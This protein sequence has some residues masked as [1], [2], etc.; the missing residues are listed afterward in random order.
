MH[1]LFSLGETQL[2][3]SVRKICARTC[4]FDVCA[5]GRVVRK[6]FDVPKSSPAIFLFLQ[7]RLFLVTFRWTLISHLENQTD[8]NGELCGLLDFALSVRYM[9]IQKI[10]DSSFSHVSFGPSCCAIWALCMCIWLYKVGLGELRKSIRGIKVFNS[11]T[12]T[13]ELTEFSQNWPQIAVSES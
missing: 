9:L 8:R 5:C 4:V 3:V 13:C 10:K 6:L 2:I 7:F 11:L 1:L 12:F